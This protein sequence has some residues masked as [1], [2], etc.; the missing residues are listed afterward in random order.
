MIPV[1]RHNPHDTP[2]RPRT[3][4]SHTTHPFAPHIPHHIHYRIAT[5]NVRTTIH[6]TQLFP[7]PQKATTLV[8][9]PHSGP[10]HDSPTYKTTPTSTSAPR[11]IHPP[12]I[13][14]HKLIAACVSI[15]APTS[16]P[17]SPINM[18][19]PLAWQVDRLRY[20]RYLP[21]NLQTSPGRA[22]PAHTHPTSTPPLNRRPNVRQTCSS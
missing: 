14:N 9:S 2:T 19:S 21:Q 12:P 17:L 15:H 5:P 20:C 1:T 3:K 4:P 18:T 10:V 7:S 13:P 6:P 22:R 11:A 8:R 16:Q